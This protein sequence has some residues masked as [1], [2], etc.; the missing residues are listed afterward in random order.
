[1]HTETDEEGGGVR[2]GYWSV[3]GNGCFVW[4]SEIMYLPSVGQIRADIVVTTISMKL[5]FRRAR[6]SSRVPCIPIIQRTGAI[7]RSCRLGRC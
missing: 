4:Y 7:I 2:K 1:M 5:W 3:L 6:E